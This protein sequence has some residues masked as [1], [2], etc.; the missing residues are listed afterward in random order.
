MAE[1]ISQSLAMAIGVAISPIPV[2][3][4]V[5]TLTTPLARANGSITRSCR[6]CAWSSPPSWSATPSRTL[7]AERGSASSGPAA[8]RQLSRGRDA[9]ANRCCHVLPLCQGGLHAGAGPRSL[10]AHDMRWP[11]RVKLDGPVTIA[12]REPPADLAI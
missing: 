2:I 11:V 5:L 9:V 8:Q 12:T 4:V 7:P 3:A 1:A 10:L 6:C